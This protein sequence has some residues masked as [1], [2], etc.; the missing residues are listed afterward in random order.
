[1][2]RRGG[3]EDGMRRGRGGDDEGMMRGQ[4]DEGMRRR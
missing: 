2:R 4:G 1:M 3:D